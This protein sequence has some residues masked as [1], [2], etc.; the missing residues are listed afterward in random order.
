M[1][2]LT[3]A[4]S[5]YASGRTRDKTG[6]FLETSKVYDW[7]LKYESVKTWINNYTCFHTRR[8]YLRGLN[9]LC[10]RLDLNPDQ[11]LELGRANGDKFPRD[12]K[13]K[14]KTILN[15]YVQKGKLGEAKTIYASLRSFL[16]CH[17]LIVT[18]SRQERVHYK[19]KKLGNEQ[20]PK[21]EQIYTMVEAVDKVTGWAD[22][23]KKLRARSLILCAFQSGVRPS[24][25]VRWHYGLVKEYLFPEIK[26]PIPIKITGSLDTK[27]QG[28]DLPYYYTF[29]GHEAAQALK[30]YL[31]AR[32]NRGANLTPE[33]Q[34]WVTS[35]SNSK[36]KPLDYDGYFRIVKR[37]T[38]A[39]G[40]P[41]Q[42]VWPHL[43]RKAFKKILNKSE[44]DDDT[45]EALMGHRIPGSRENYFDRHDPADAATKYSQC[46]FTNTPDD[47]RDLV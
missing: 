15:E 19:R 40:L 2:R 26:T 37:V 43:L 31:E 9:V 34:I 8:L 16:S 44:I 21:K 32:I 6:A 3:T 17:E 35:A 29:I 12:L 1:A 4:Q 39:A 33:S 25:L 13:T 20:I 28:Y 27:L 10:M 36:N 30:E 22:P 5:E 24:C 41:T 11:I 23:L 14:I 42:Q 45:R 47:T 7:L 18:F 38:E 46:N